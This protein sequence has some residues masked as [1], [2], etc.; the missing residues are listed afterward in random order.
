MNLR[1]LNNPKKQ[2]LDKAAHTPYTKRCIPTQSNTIL[3]GTGEITYEQNKDT[4]QYVRQVVSV[5]KC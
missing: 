1:T 3:S 2:G 5:G 4:M